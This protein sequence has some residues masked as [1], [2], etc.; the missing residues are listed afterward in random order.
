MAFGRYPRPNSNH[1]PGRNKRG[2]RT[3]GDNPINDGDNVYGEHEDDQRPEDT[4]GRRPFQPR[5]QEYPNTRFENQS[6]RPKERPQQGDEDLLAG[7]RVV[8]TTEIIGEEAQRA[9][10]PQESEQ[11]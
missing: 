5:R 2:R 7:I 8:V 9:A 10:N 4:R 3:E 1:R 11:E 6:P